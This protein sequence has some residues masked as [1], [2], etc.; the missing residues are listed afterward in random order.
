MTIQFEDAL[1]GQHGE[2]M[3]QVAEKAI[4]DAVSQMGKMFTGGV[5]AGGTTG[6]FASGGPVSAGNYRIGDGV[7]EAHI[8]N[9]GGV[10]FD[11]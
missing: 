11:I 7:R 8:P 3:K 4:S 9:I 1:A 2:E 5:I 10:K 6:K